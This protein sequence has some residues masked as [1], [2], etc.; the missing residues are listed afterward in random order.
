VGFASYD[1]DVQ[2]RLA[3]NL[4]DRTVTPTAATSPNDVASKLEN[5]HAGT[6]GKKKEATMAVQEIQANQARPLPVF[7]LADVSGSMAE[8][9]KIGSLNQG[10]RELIAALGQAGELFAQ[11]QVG[12]VTFG[13]TSAQLHQQLT[14]ATGVR[15]S[16]MAADGMTPMGAAF[17]TVRAQIEDRAVVPSRAY[18]PVLV[19]VSDGQPNDVWEPALDELLTSERGA[20]ADRFALAIGPD[21]DRAMLERFTGNRER[22]LHVQEAKGILR[23]FQ[24]VTMSVLTRSRAVQPN[25]A[26]PPP[27]LDWDV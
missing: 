10:V 24:F 21:A 11:P 5:D 9:G 26:L 17:R 16:D 8:A 23:F 7:V 12:V 18:R 14:P 6:G 27:D 19:L 3:H 4:R 25:Q 22:V 1:E 13:G 20:K 2:S 15:W